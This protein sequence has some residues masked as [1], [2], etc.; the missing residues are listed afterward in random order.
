MKL[1]KWLLMSAILFAIPT[2]GQNQKSIDVLVSKKGDITELI[3]NSV[4]AK[5]NSNSRYSV[6]NHFTETTVNLRMICLQDEIE[7]GN[8]VGYTCASTIVVSWANDGFE[9]FIGLD[10]AAGPNIDSVSQSIYESFIN[11]T[12]DSIMKNAAD[13]FLSA[14]SAIKT[15]LENEKKDAPQKF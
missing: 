7:N 3:G 12:N 1:T 11:D 8:K 13:Y 6:V 14:V 15:Y 2:F 10:L 9:D 4:E 5:I